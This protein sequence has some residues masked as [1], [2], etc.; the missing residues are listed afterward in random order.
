MEYTMYLLQTMQIKRACNVYY[1][2]LFLSQ[3]C[4][5]SDSNLLTVWDVRVREKNTIQDLVFLA[6]YGWYQ[7]VYVG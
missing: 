3:A 4:S 2:L 7:G 5:L 6:N 1:V